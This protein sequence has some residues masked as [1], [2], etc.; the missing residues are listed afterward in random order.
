MLKYICIWGKRRQKKYS[1]EVVGKSEECF[2]LETKASI[3][4]VEVPR[5]V[6]RSGIM[7]LK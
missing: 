3:G 4:L 7:N 6:G 2:M 5:M 1:G